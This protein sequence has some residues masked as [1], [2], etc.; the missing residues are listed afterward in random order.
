MG[1]FAARS[2]RLEH[3]RDDPHGLCV[4]LAA[5]R[6]PAADRD[7]HH[8]RGRDRAADD[9]SSASIPGS[10]ISSCSSCRSGENCHRRPRSP[11]RYRRASPKASFMR[12]MYEALKI[13]LPITLM[14]FAIFTRS[15]YSS[16]VRAGSR[17]GI[18]LLVVDRH[19]RHGL[20]DVRAHSRSGPAPRYRAARRRSRRWRCSCCSIR[21]TLWRCRVAT[22]RARARSSGIWRHGIVASPPRRS[23]EQAGAGG[24]RNQARILSALVAERRESARS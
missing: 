11:P 13:C 1:A 19:L 18:S 20:R 8:R 4:R 9:R 17:S 14:T 21:T 24:R 10:R 12:T 16:P 7:L 15:G 3:H 23:S 22:L 2:R 5:R 6:R